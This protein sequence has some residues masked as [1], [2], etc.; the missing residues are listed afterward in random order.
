MGAA[1][2]CDRVSRRVSRA[3]RHASGDGDREQVPCAVPGREPVVLP[4]GVADMV[5]VGAR[6]PGRGIGNCPQYG[7]APS[8]GE[9]ALG[10]EALEAQ[11]D[12]LVG[13]AEE[14]GDGVE[15]AGRHGAWW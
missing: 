12:L 2:R 15:F 3:A 8:L 1:P 4:V 11:S 9:P 10:D 13:H 5:G 6:A 7:L 14:S